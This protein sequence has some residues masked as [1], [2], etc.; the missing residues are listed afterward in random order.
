MLKLSNLGSTFA[1]RDR[2]RDIAGSCPGSGTLVVDAGDV[3]MSPS[4]VAELLSEL[5]ERF[6][7]IRFVRADEHTDYL[8]TD[9]ARKLGIA[10]RVAVESVPDSESP[11][12]RRA[13]PAARSSDLATKEAGRM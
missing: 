1:S 4:F 11:R 12:D 10:E 8:V 13:S 3:Y 5:D 6:S 2:A 9:L 7:A